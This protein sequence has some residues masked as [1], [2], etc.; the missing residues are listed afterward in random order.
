M[1]L[2]FMD[3]HESS[4]L[5]FFK[6][7]K[8]WYVSNFHTLKYWANFTYIHRFE[9]DKTFEL[10]ET[11]SE[12]HAGIPLS[13]WYTCTCTKRTNQAKDMVGILPTH[14]CKNGNKLHIY[15]DRTMRSP[16]AAWL[17]LDGWEL[18]WLVPLKQGRDIVGILFKNGNKLH[19]CKRSNMRDPCTTQF[20]T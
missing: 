19:S 18:V 15:K 14:V 10:F 1:H 4:L 8:L 2:I 12:V 13:H 17:L 9:V 11:F 6:L 5:T 7:R 16:C 20:V 3:C